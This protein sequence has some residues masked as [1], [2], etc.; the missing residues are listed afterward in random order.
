LGLTYNSPK[1]IYINILLILTYINNIVPQGLVC[2]S[3]ILFKGYR[4]LASA[5]NIKTKINENT[6]TNTNNNIIKNNNNNEDEDKNNN[7]NF[8]INILNNKD[9]I[10]FDNLLDEKVNISI[11][12]ITKNMIG[13]Y[14]IYN[15]ITG[16]Y[17]IG[18]SYK[19]I[20]NRYLEHLK[21]LKTNKI[22]K[23]TVLKYG[24]DNFKFMIIYYKFEED[25]LMNNN[26]KREKIYKKLL[27]IEE[28][29]IELYKPKYNIL[30]KTSTGSSNYKHTEETKLKLKAK[31]S[32]RLL[33][34]T[35][36]NKNKKF[37]E[38]HINNLRI[39]ALN[40]PPMSEETKLKCI[41]SNKPIMLYFYE[42]INNENI[43]NNNE[44]YVYNSIKELSI[45]L[46]CSY[47]TIYRALKY[48]DGYLN[49]KYLIKSLNK[50]NIY[51]LLVFSNVANIFYILYYVYIYI[52]LLF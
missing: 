45:D 21:Y 48:K 11:K 40:R 52:Y 28:N 10:I 16:N 15:K 36:L 23:K 24:I 38:E 31:S 17:Y 4:A 39:A 32:E 18:S 25:L 49:K 6:N 14:L 51:L 5:D 20:Y 8:K 9:I 3:L 22:L 26:I 30:I 2:S 13:V 35:N 33:F 7:N 41:K 12:K 19:R 44:Y 1:Y 27:K 42:K 34:I 47:K 50:I 37:S 43:I 29:Y 46:G